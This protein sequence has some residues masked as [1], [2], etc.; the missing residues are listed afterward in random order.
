MLLGQYTHF[1]QFLGHSS[2]SSIPFCRRSSRHSVSYSFRHFHRNF[3]V[4]SGVVSVTFP[5]LLV[6]VSVPLVRMWRPANTLRPIAQPSWSLA[7]TTRRR[8]CRLACDHHQTVLHGTIAFQPQCSPDL[9]S[10]DSSVERAEDTARSVSNSCQPRRI[11]GTYDPRVPAAGGCSRKWAMFGS[12]DYIHGTIHSHRQHHRHRQ[13]TCLPD[14]A[15]CALKSARGPAN[16]RKHNEK[17]KGP[18]FCNV[19]LSLVRSIFLN[20]HALNNMH[21]CCSVHW[22]FKNNFCI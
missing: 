12:A 14:K 10:S 1:S 20:N 13:H 16:G 4:C 9:S 11:A 6:C 3:W 22:V 19:Q 18:Y 17:M 21:C 2:R 7:W 15:T 5:C 8:T